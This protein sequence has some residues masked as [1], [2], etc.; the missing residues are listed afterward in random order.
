MQVLSDRVMAEPALLNG[1]KTTPD[2][3]FLAFLRG[4]PDLDEGAAAAFF[5]AAIAEADVI[6]TACLESPKQA[7]QLFNMLC[8]ALTVAGGSAVV[9]EQ[10]AGL[11]C[12]VG[13]TLVAADPKLA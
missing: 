6:G 2:S 5:G 12:A 1:A 3:A 13:S 7:W 11:L 4:L 9:S 10:V 8:Q